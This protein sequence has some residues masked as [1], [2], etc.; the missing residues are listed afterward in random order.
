MWQSLYHKELSRCLQPFK[1][2]TLLF[3]TRAKIDH[4]HIVFHCR[5]R[6]HVFLH[7]PS[8]S[9]KTSLLALISSIITPNSGDIEVFGTNLSNMNLRQRDR[10]R[11]D[12]MGY[13]FKCSTLFPISTFAIM[14]YSPKNELENGSNVKTL[15]RSQNSSITA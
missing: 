4:K 5:K 14:F 15:K 8:G 1:S 6:E 2:K 9:G 12:N 3:L 13:I 11:G 10:F 7:G